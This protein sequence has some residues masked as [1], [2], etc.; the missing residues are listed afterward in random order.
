MFSTKSFSKLL[1]LL[2]ILLTLGCKN[3]SRET[4]PIDM[5]VAKIS[6]TALI[7]QPT[8]IATLT[9]SATTTISSDLN[10]VQYKCLKIQD[11]I[12]Q[13]AR[14]EG[15]LVLANIKDIDLTDLLLLD[16]NSDEQKILPNE[17]IGLYSVSPEGTFL[18]YDSFT[19][20]HNQV[21]SRVIKI[22]DSGGNLVTSI[23][24]Q[25]NWNG[26]EWLNEENLM[27][28]YTINGNPLIL[29]S[30]LKHN[31]KLIRPYLNVSEIMFADTE[32]IYYWGFYAFHKNVYDP[33]LER[34]LYPSS[35]Q[36]GPKIVLRDIIVGKDLAAFPTNDAWGVSPKWS[37]DG[38]NIAIGLN[39]NVSARN[40]GN[41]KYE[42]FIIGRD[43]EK[44]LTTNLSSLSDSTY[45]YTISWSPDSR[46]VAFWYTTNKNKINE[47]LELAVLDTK[48]K[49]ITN[50]CIS[51][52]VEDLS[53]RRNDLSPI[54]SPNSNY[55]LINTIIPN[56]HTL[57]ALIVDV[58][59]GHATLVKSGFLPV[60]WMR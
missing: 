27:I 45:I 31:Q 22:I 55:L 24:W 17:Y 28:N 49:K 50:Y 39:T 3:G 34:A 57:E 25:E 13:P 8:N 44:L 43:G 46:Y 35:D 10:E 19:F 48:T 1:S 12:I 9:S 60:G 29:L 14:I 41:R 59:N 30:P 36:N 26:F 52:T 20:E 5:P 18:A 47:N 2:L 4:T 32:L 6:P 40:D 11:Q 16:L 56:T 38:E 53:S 21:T 42:L 23:D 7:Q 15:T 37:P 54:W 51:D 58:I 33:Q